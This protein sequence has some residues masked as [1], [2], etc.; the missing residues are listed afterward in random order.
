MWTLYCGNYDSG[1][2]MHGHVQLYWGC[3]DNADYSNETCK[4]LAAMMELK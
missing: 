3:D 1:T 2:L 4:M